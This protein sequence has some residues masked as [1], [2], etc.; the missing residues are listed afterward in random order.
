LASSGG[1]FALF[2]FVPIIVVGLYLFRVLGGPAVDW[3]GLAPLGSVVQMLVIL[4]IFAGFG[5]EFGWRGF[6][7]PRMQ[8]RHNAL[9]STIIVWVVHSLWHIPLFLI[10][11]MNQYAWVQE[12]GFITAYLGYVAGLF[13]WTIMYTWVFNNTR[14]SVLL[15]AVV[16]GM[17]NFWAGYLDNY[18]GIYATSLVFGVVLLVVGVVI[19]LMAGPENLSR[20]YER[21]VIGLEE[22]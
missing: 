1:P 20:K 12:V 15:A 21:N 19:I 9:V 14:G 11:G 6:L 13:G 17:G 3:S 16:H 10:E 4:I 8:A 5:E 2:S 22:G 18:R 7:L